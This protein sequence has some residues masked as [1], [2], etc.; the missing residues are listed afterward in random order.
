M[1]DFLCSTVCVPSPATECHGARARAVDA[2]G[3]P[4]LEVL[5]D[6]LPFVKRDNDPASALLEAW[7]SRAGHILER[8]AHDRWLLG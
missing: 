7:T 4:R 1:G 3:W 8:G 5:L 6:G 2:A